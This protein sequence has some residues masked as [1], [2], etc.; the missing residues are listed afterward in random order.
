MNSTN[1]PRAGLS[2]RDRKLLLAF[3][4]FAEA[5]LLYMLMVDPLLTRLSR[6]S[7]LEETT[8]AAHVELMATVRSKAS[9]ALVGAEDRPLAPMVLGVDET[10]TIAIQQALD[11]MARG[12]G[13]R[14]M[15]ASVNAVSESRGGLD[16]HGVTVELEGAYEAIA[17]FV[18]E[19]EA[20]DPVRGVEQLT[21]TPAAADPDRIRVA[22]TLRFYLRRA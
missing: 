6:A 22:L 3:G 13:V 21:I 2:A 5:A 18:E 19:L 4:L 7:S 11:E 17:T 1:A 16:S 20:A 8:R 10:A 14:L 9:D 12:A 15:Q